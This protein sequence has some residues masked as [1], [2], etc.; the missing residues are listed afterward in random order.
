MQGLIIFTALFVPLATYCML[1][2]TSYFYLPPPLSLPLPPLAPP[3]PPPPPILSPPISS[4][5]YPP[6]PPPPHSV[7]LTIKSFTDSPLDQLDHAHST[8][9]TV[10]DTCGSPMNDFM[11]DIYIHTHK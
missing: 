6:P 5:P 2:F 1:T 9:P 4:L 8:G 3:P 7:K 11:M 10:S